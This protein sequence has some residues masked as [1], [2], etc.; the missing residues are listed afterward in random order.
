MA[1]I[2]NVIKGFFF[3]QEGNGELIVYKWIVNLNWKCSIKRKRMEYMRDELE[4][5]G[6]VRVRN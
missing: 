5:E 2:Y 6:I 1:Y 4:M 3:W